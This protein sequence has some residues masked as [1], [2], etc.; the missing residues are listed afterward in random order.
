ARLIEPVSTMNVPATAFSKV[1]FPEPFVPMMIRNEPVSSRS[2]TPRNARTSLGVPGLNVLPMLEISSMSGGGGF[3][4]RFEFA[5]Q[6]GCD[7]R[8][9]HKCGGDEFQIIWIQPPAQ[10]EGHPQGKE[11]RSPHRAQDA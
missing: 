6:R 5:N 3:R 4:G 11:H 10:P 2:E 7:E 8:D 9:E 1:D